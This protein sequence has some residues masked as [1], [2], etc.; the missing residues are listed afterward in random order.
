VKQGSYLRSVAV[1]ASSNFTIQVLGTASGFALAYFLQPE[2]RGAYA[3]VMAWSGALCIIGGLGLTAAIC[4]FVAAGDR[5]DDFLRTAQWLLVGLSLG[6]MLIGL[7][8]TP[9]VGGDNDDLRLAFL[10]AFLSLPV[11]VLSGTWVFALQGAD[12]RRWAAVRLVHPVAYLALLTVLYGMGSLTVPWVISA[13]TASAATQ[14][15]FAYDRRLAPPLIGYG[16]RTLASQAPFL[17]NSRVDQ[18][19]LSVAVPLS[20]L[21]R[22]AVAVSLTLVVFPLTSAFGNVALPRI[23]RLSHTDARAA[24]A[25][26][27]QAV[28]GSLAIGGIGA[29]VIAALTPVAVPLVFGES[30]E[31]IELLVYILAPGAVLLGLNQVLGDV[32]RGYNQALLVARAEGMAAVLTLVLMAALIP[33]LG[34]VGAAISSTC[35]Y[36][37]AAALLMRYASRHGLERTTAAASPPASI[38]P[39]ELPGG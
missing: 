12:L 3:A 24:R 33:T 7:V 4:Y 15:T 28:V 35:S 10:I 14:A 9:F 29:A 26:W 34:V 38:T 17:L 37:L 5:R 25:T 31:G 36:G 27:R 19:V 13:V 1:A 39:P 32:L 2:G 18:L 8:L 6:A 16:L 11:I 22:Y 30:Y 21:G 20:D 23:A